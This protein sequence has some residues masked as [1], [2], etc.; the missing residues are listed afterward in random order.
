MSF[1]MNWS[2]DFCLACDRQTS[3]GAYCSQSCRLADIEG[4][5]ESVSPMTPCSPQS[6]NVPP[7]SPSSR[8][9]LP[10][11]FNFAA[12]KSSSNPANPL[13]TAREAPRVSSQFSYF[14]TAL[15][16]S[17]STS[18]SNAVS[19]AGHGLTPSSSQSSLSSIQSNSSQE[20]YLSTQARNELR[21]YASSFDH[22]RDSR[23]RMTT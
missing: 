8:F 18:P 5:P 6:F 3:G 16:K 12:Y 15:P 10:P 2:P 14:S 20:G 11:P 17:K 4:G 21:G 19:S 9:Y 22:V 13:N 1:E 7:T 23:R